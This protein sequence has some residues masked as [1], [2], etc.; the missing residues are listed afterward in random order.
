MK[1]RNAL[2]VATTL[3]LL[4]TN[5][6]TAQTPSPAV[7]DKQLPGWTDY[8]DSLRPLGDRILPVTQ[9]P[10]NPQSRQETWRILMQM[11][12]Q[13]VIVHVYDNPDYPE[14]T[15]IYSSVL[16]LFAPNVDYIYGWTSVR[17]SGVYR[18]KGFRG[19]NRFVDL[20]FV[21]GPGQL[22]GKHAPVLGT[23]DLDTLNLG[24]DGA[25]DVLVSPKRPDGYTG[26]WFQM[27]P[28]T[29]AVQYRQASYD[30][31][32]ERDAII[33]IQRLDVPAPRPRFTAEELAQRFTDLKN[34]IETGSLIFLNRVRD[35]KAQGIVNRVAV[36][37][38]S[39]WG[40]AKDQTYLEGLYDIRDDEALIVETQVPKTCRYWSILL[41]D[42]QFATVD[43]MNRQSSLN[44]Y[45]AALDKDGKFRA[46]IAV[47]DP[48]VPNW[49][50]TGGYWRNTNAMEPL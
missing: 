6:S 44:G 16:N 25:Y 27:P 1:T 29:T 18:I 14:F 11:L 39:A 3:F 46:V 30:W 50:D 7:N 24:P 47:K 35:M 38:Y 12:A 2:L 5:S 49:L 26:D 28:G 19:T 36:Q 43:W 4:N 41:T 21:L 13:G 34:W 8:L 31:L 9:F 48:G 32:H 17:D 20:S 22:L 10:D 33:T 37:D 40:G 23:L 15:P 42:D 45:Q